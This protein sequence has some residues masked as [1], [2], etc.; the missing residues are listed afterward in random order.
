M[1]VSER[2]VKLLVR[3]R[4]AVFTSVDHELEIGLRFAIDTRGR[5]VVAAVNLR[6]IGDQPCRFVRRFPANQFQFHFVDPQPGLPAVR[7][8]HDGIP[9]QRQVAKKLV[10]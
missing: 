7:R 9:M 10:P 3:S 2:T 8:Q 6:E 4:T 1:L 5:L